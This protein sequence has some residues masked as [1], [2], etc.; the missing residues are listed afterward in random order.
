MSVVALFIGGPMHGKKMTLDH[1]SP[2]WEMMTYDTGVD[3]FRLEKEIS[4]KPLKI[5]KIRYKL[6]DNCPVKY[7]L[8][9]GADFV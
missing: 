2:V 6:Y 5:K 8:D 7:I 3:S 1:M 4:D 9:K